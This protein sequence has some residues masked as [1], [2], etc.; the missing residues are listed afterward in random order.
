MSFIVRMICMRT[1]RKHLQLFVLILI[2]FFFLLLF[3]YFCICMIW[4]LHERSW[5]FHD[6]PMNR[7]N[8]RIRTHWALTLH[9]VDYAFVSRTFCRGD[10]ASVNHWTWSNPL[11][12]FTVCLRWRGRSWAARR[13]LRNNKP[14]RYRWIAA[15]KMGNAGKNVG[16][17]T[18][19][20]LRSLNMYAVANVIVSVSAVACCIWLNWR[21]FVWV[22]EWVRACAL[23]MIWLIFCHLIN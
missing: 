17:A 19:D 6:D 2:D 4:K 1:F 15:D 12:K 7:H 16:I 11:C 5:C 20:P 8:T 21:V 14:S 9:A 22:N 3:V 23:T 13:H 10:N 18:A